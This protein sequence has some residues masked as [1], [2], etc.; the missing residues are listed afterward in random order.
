MSEHF[1]DDIDR[2]A[3]LTEVANESAVANARM[4]A[5]PEQVRNADGTWPTTECVEC[6]ELIEEARLDMGKVRCFECQ[7]TLEKRGRQHVR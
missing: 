4:K 3:F 2:A 7:S 6:G 5:R 1:A